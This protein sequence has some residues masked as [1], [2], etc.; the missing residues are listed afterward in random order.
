[1]TTSTIHDA[2]S[3]LAG[4]PAAAADADDLQ[5]WLQQAFAAERAPQPARLPVPLNAAA[6]PAPRRRR[7]ASQAVRASFLWMFALSLGSLL[8]V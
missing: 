4:A 8:L 5:R 7:Q 1:M 3:I 6:V 2:T